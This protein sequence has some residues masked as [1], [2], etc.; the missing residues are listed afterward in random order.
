LNG[1]ASE[2]ER[3]KEKGINEF[4]VLLISFSLVFI[5]G[6]GILNTRKKS[7]VD[8]V[9]QIEIV[10]RCEIVLFDKNIGHSLRWCINAKE[11]TL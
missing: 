6:F 9:R 11:W 1:Q 5:I 10:G 8:G 2:N 4:V 3:K 7:I